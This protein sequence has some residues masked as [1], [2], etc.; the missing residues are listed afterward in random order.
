MANIAI[1]NFT[2]AVVDLARFLEPFYNFPE[3]KTVKQTN[4]RILK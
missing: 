3:L 1:F 4:E 2:K